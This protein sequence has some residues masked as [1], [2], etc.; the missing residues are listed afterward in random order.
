MPES[1]NPITSATGQVSLPAHNPYLPHVDDIL[2]RL[3]QSLGDRYAVEREVGRGG[4]ATVY[5]ATDLKHQ[6]SVAI[7]VLLPELAASVGHDRFLQE[8]GIAAKLQH[9]HILPVYDSGEADGLLYYVMPFVEGESLRDLIVRQ[10][11]L[12]PDQALLIAREVAGALDFAHRSG[13]VHRDIK[14][15][16]ILISD[17]H[18]VV[19]DFGIARA[20]SVSGSQGLTQAGMAIGTPSYMSPEQALGETDLD[21][22]TDVY[23]LGSVLYEMMAG[24]PPF[25]GTSPQAIVAK[26]ISATIPKLE[27]DT[28]GVQPVIERAMAKEPGDRFQT[29]GEMERALRSGSTSLSGPVAQPR[30]RSMMVGAVAIVVV[31][32]AAVALWPRGWSVEGDPRHSLIVFPFENKTAE[33]DKDY[34]E[35]ASMNLLGLAIAQWEDMRVYDD[36]RTGSLMRRRGVDSARDLDFDAA[37]RMAK[38]AHVGTLVLGDIRREGD[39][40]SIEAKVHDVQTGDRIAT[41]IVRTGR[42]A[43]PRPVFDSLAARV[44]SVSGAPPGERPGLVAQTTHSLEAYRAYLRGVEA[45]Q[46]FEIDDA[47][48]ALTL[49][50]EIDTTFALAYLRLRDVDGWAGIEAS[51]A[52]RREWTA[53]AQAHSASL[54]PSVRTLVQFYVAY[55]NGD[56]ERARELARELIAKDSTDVEAWYQLGEAHFHDNA[57]RIPHEPEYGN[58]GKALRAFERAREIDPR[59]LLAYR[60]ILDVLGNCAA[61]NPWLCL[62]DSAVYASQADL[63]AQYG[64]DE[65]ERIRA[66][67]RTGQIDAAYAWIDAA[68]QSPIARSV[69]IQLLIE[70]DRPDDAR[71]QLGA[72]RASGGMTEAR[73]WEA[74]LLLRGSAYGPA[75]DTLTAA[76][77]DPLALRTLL[78]GQGP[79]R[80]FAALGAGARIERI[81]ALLGQILDLLAGRS[82]VANGPGGMELPITVLADLVDFQMAAGFAVDPDEV[83]RLAS[84]WMDTVD[85]LFAGDDAGHQHAL[86]STGASILQ[87]Y[88]TTRD[89]TMLVRFLAQIDTSASRTWRV[90]DAFLALARGDTAHAVMRID[91][92]VRQADDREFTG[93]PGSVRSFAWADLLVHLGEHEEAIE[94][95]GW[96]DS[97]STRLARPMLQVRSWPERGALYQ[98]LGEP[99]KA[100]EMYQLFI[101][102]W[103]GGDDGVQPQVERARSAVAALQ[104]QVD[105]PAETPG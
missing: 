47:R 69:L 18:A 22:R 5:L 102:A 68:P 19:A 96:L 59:Y 29:A 86:A 24:S 41:E 12:E 39:S 62:A 55:E 17:G 71:V 56:L 27:R 37:Q 85:S 33:D 44:L 6:R 99:D 66:E 48:E 76:L 49:A 79:D 8:I 98:Q 84:W 83:R 95:F 103:S 80:A 14:P 63:D 13:V 46:Q 53:K 64:A 28:V 105:L 60:H 35:D 43:D 36:E 1:R 100:I 4:M 10:G 54:P 77:D 65:V 82:N 89:T 23:A 88:V 34:W 30:K 3:Q 38:D 104:G 73:I 20:I 58:M 91:R 9:P 52:R 75:A 16:N 42:D 61:N 67:A 7:K 94:V 74:T 31:A 70:R 32:A 21:G 97:T 87:A 40:L 78:T 25:E 101:E 11:Q 93:E 51:P 90:M 92:H 50:V 45:L 2:K 72:L 57:G 81:Q 26:T 15:A